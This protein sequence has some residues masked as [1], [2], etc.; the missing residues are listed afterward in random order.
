MSNLFNNKFTLD[1]FFDNKKSILPQVK[2]EK[3]KLINKERKKYV[4]DI[5][6]EKGDFDINETA[7]VDIVSQ[8]AI[9]SASKHYK[10]SIVS[11]A[12]ATINIGGEL[13]HAHNL[14]MVVEDVYQ[15]LITNKGL[16]KQMIQNYNML[17]DAIEFSN[18]MYKK[19]HLYLT[20]NSKSQL[21]DLVFLYSKSAART[22][23]MTEVMQ[24]I[25][26]NDAFKPIQEK[27]GIFEEKMVR[28]NNT[29]R[30]YEYEK[31]RWKKRVGYGTKN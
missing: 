17:R 31:E 1:D 10:E 23:F 24:N 7:L 26:F 27:Y 2:T 11:L 8:I 5:R 25:Y 19:P 4:S 12:G 28:N 3:D 20:L 30:N 9:G 16:I 18:K 6:R 29:L 14:N 13:K 15:A 22:K 21:K